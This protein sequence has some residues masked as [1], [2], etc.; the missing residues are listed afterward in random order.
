MWWQ[1]RPNDNLGRSIAT[2]R[3]DSAKD[4]DFKFLSVREINGEDGP[5]VI[6]QTSQGSDVSPELGPTSSESVK[7]TAQSDESGGRGN[8]RQASHD[9]PKDNMRTVHGR[10]FQNVEHSEKNTNHEKKSTPDTAEQGQSQIK[11]ILK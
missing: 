11:R 5:T 1:A 10:H 3:W 2:F 8:E 4:V 7:G 9:E 6:P